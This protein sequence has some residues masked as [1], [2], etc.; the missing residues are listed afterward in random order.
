MGCLDLDT[1]SGFRGAFFFAFPALLSLL[2]AR[3]RSNGA[4]GWGGEVW[5]IA[6]CTHAC[7][8]M[9]VVCSAKITLCYA[10]YVGRCREGVE[11]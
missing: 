4:T 9:M 2:R 7:V 1:I 6:V 5:I 3:L 8:V 10:L 11:W